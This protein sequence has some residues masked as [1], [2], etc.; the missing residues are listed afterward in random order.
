M[1]NLAGCDCQNNFYVASDLLSTYKTF[2]DN[3]HCLWGPG[4]HSFVFA[5]IL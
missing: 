3:A 4:F 2:P 1:Q 5:I